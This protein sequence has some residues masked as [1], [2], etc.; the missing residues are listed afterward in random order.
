MKKLLAI[1]LCLLSVFSLM[2]L[3]GCNNAN[4]TTEEKT[5]NTEENT[6]EDSA[7]ESD[8][9]KYELSEEEYQKANSLLTLYKENIKGDITKSRVSGVLYWDDWKGP[10]TDDSSY[11]TFAVVDMNGDGFSEMVLERLGEHCVIFY[12]HK[13]DDIDR[14][15]FG[16]REMYNI[17]E[18]GTFAWNRTSNVGHEYGCA[19][20]DQNMNKTYLYTIRNDG[21]D[22]AEYFV[23]NLPVTQEELKQYMSQFKDVELDF[24]DLNSENLDKYITIESITK[25]LTN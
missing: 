3:S 7:T 6:T 11:Y 14:R 22:Q 20:L 21:T 17:R 2:A 25:G 16:F 9:V 10:A 13:K 5:A 1:V 8:T 15:H 18:N 24:Y 12:N 4:E 19:R 23:N